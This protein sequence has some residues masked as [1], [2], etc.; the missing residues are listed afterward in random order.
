MRVKITKKSLLGNR[1]VHVAIMAIRM[2]MM[3]TRPAYS[4]PHDNLQYSIKAYTLYMV[5]SI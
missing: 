4:R 3:V 5:S 1:A 2:D